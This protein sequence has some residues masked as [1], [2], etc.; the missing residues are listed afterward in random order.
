MLVTFRS[1]ETGELM[2]FADVARQLLVACGK[3][4]TARGTFIPEEMQPAADRLRRAIELGEAPPPADENQPKDEDA[5][6]PV[7]LGRRAWPLLDMLERT[8]RA[9]PKAHVVWEAATDF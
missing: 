3:E 9:G 8:G 1:S 4:C 5:P 6:P 7:S 2:M